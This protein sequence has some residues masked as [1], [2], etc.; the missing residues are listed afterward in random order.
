MGLKINVHKIK[1]LLVRKDQGGYIENVR[2]SGKGIK[3]MMKIKHLGLRISTDEEV[4]HKL[5]KGRKICQTLLNFW[6]EN[7][8]SLEMRR[9]LYG[10]VILTVLYI[11]EIWSFKRSGDRK[12]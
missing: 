12:T 9:A 11:S 8:L 5:D 2:V 1:V 3:E 7:T 10:V 4:T 6:K